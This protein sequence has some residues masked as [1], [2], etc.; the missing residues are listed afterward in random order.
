[1]PPHTRAILNI[2]RALFHPTTLSRYF[3]ILSLSFSFSSSSP[4]TSLSYFSR[5][6]LRSSSFPSH[7][8]VSLIAFSSSSP[9]LFLVV[10]F[11]FLFVLYQD[12]QTYS[13]VSLPVLLF[14]FHVHLV[15]TIIRVLLHHL[16]L[17]A[18]CFSVSIHS[19]LTSILLILLLYYS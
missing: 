5:L 7:L 17:H 8:Y 15:T 13:C 16:L 12:F 3:L 2:I 11:L 6:S 14:S 9:F 18:F 4:S 10:L 19:T 1:M